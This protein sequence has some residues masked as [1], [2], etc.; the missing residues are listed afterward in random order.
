MY[1]VWQLRVN[2]LN[3]IVSQTQHLSEW[4]IALMY[5]VYFFYV[6]KVL[7]IFFWYLDLWESFLQSDEHRSW[8]AYWQILLL[9]LFSLFILNIVCSD[10]TQ[11]DNSG[12]SVWKP[13]FGARDVWGLCWTEYHDGWFFFFNKYFVFY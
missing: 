2:K 13:R 7:L 10:M 12:F 5:K 3:F 9:S 1:V 4:N 11:A 8:R 6:I